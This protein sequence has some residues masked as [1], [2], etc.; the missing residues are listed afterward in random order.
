MPLIYFDTYDPQTT[1][2]ET[3]LQVVLQS[4]KKFKNNITESQNTILKLRG[5]THICTHAHTYVHIYVSNTGNQNHDS[6]YSEP[7]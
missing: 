6:I 3:N 5:N 1:V 7:F 2:W 4:I